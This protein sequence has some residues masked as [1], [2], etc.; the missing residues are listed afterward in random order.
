[1]ADADENYAYN[2]AVVVTFVECG[3]FTASL[4]LMTAGGHFPE[5]RNVN[6]NDILAGGVS[7]LLYAAVNQLQFYGIRVSGAA[8]YQ[9]L[10]NS[11]VVWTGLLSMLL[12]HK[13]LSVTQWR[14]LVLLNLGVFAAKWPELHQELL[15][16]APTLRDPD[17]RT[18]LVVWLSGCCGGSEAS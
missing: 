4:L 11:K 5:V 15:S 13:A 8:G 16:R 2:P 7:A 18:C 14:G 6:F 17:A 9:I 1:M 12:F 10:V 3:K